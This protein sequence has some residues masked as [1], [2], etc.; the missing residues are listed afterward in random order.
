MSSTAL[1]T[2]GRFRFVASDRTSRPWITLLA[3]R[4]VHITGAGSSK[5]KYVSPAPIENRI[6]ASHL[7]EMS[8]VSGVGQ[9]S[10]YAIVVLNEQ[11]RSKQ[12]DQSV[13]SQVAQE[14]DKL[15]QEVNA[16]LPNY[17]R[18]QMFVELNRYAV[19]GPHRVRSQP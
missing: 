12:H 19:V 18:L 5:G 16:G 15:L 9:P 7:I 14:L 8:M 11:V 1:P 6:N 10:A 4:G 17:E 3:L 13:R 2:A